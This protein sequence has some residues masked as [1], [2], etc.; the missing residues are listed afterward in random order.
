MYLF[1]YAEEHISQRTN[2]MLY[3]LYRPNG[4]SVASLNVKYDYDDDPTVIL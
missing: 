2:I 3:H 4:R 1:I